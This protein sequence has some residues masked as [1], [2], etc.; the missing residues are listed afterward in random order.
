MGVESADC[1]IIGAGITGLLSAHLLVQRGLSVA[2]VEKGE[3]AR[4][5]TWAGGGIVS[6]MYPW[7]YSD[8]VNQLAEYGQQHYPVFLDELKRETGIDPELLPSGMLMLDEPEPEMRPWADRWHARIEE[9]QSREELEQVQPGLDSRFSSGLWM[10]DI[11]QVRNPRLAKALAERARQTPN[12]SIKTGQAVSEIL[13][14]RQRA[15]GVRLQDGSEVFGERVLITAGAWTGSIVPEGCGAEIEVFPVK[16]QI[17]LFKGEP[18]LLTRMV[19]REGRYLI[20]RKDG[21]ILIGSTL[22][23]ADF[24]KQTTEEALSELR[25]SAIDLVPAVAELPVVHQWA[26]LRPGSKDGVPYIGECPDVA[27]LFI[28]AG[29]YRN[30]IVTGL[31]S[32]QLGVQLMAGE[33]PLF[34]PAPYRPG[35]T[36][37]LNL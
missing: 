15:K 24:D 3:L 32:A 21:L 14:A 26:G 12:I 13:I 23:F 20:P 9:L 22:E 33:A 16:G 37:S 6:P 36:K 27:G 5:S 17:V 28:N 19:M 10:P 18:G 1:V 8:A 34:D 4:E 35:G 2:L 29:Q 30:G 7:R 31:A 25:A 11:Q